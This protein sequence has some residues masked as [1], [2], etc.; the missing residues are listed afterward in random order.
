[1]TT[2]PEPILLTFLLPDTNASKTSTIDLFKAYNQAST[3]HR[4]AP[5]D[6]LDRWAI[7]LAEQAN[8]PALTTKQAHAVWRQVSTAMKERRETDRKQSRDDCLLALLY[9]GTP[10]SYAATSPREKQAWL[11]AFPQANAIRSLLYTPQPKSPDD[12]SE[13]VEELTGDSKAA[14]QVRL[15]LL[16]QQKLK[17]L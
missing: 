3:I 6:W 5:D 11:A 4:L 16:I 13:L 7:W 10:A 15:D 1:M 14:R 9:G 8:L 12:V 2:L 17:S